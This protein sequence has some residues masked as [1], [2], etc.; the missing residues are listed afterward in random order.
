MLFKDGG[1][2]VSLAIENKSKATSNF[3][4][5]TATK[6]VSTFHAM[7]G[8][9]KKNKDEMSMWKHT[10]APIRTHTCTLGSKAAETMLK[11]CTIFKY[12]I[13]R[14]KHT[15]LFV[16]T[17]LHSSRAITPGLKVFKW[18]SGILS[19]ANSQKHK[20]IKATVKHIWW[21]FFLFRLRSLHISHSWI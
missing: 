7:A 21:L 2:Q 12:C 1:I 19:T 15:S 5:N 16:S 8:E 13:Y 20:E 4:T 6:R 18:A 14:N 17:G 10:R 11:I 3:R 9:K